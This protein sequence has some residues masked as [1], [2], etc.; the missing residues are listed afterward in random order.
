MFVRYASVYPL[1]QCLSITPV[2]IHYANVYPLRQ[3][4]SITPVIV[5]YA[6]V[7]PLH[8]FTYF[9]IIK[10]N[11]LISQIYFGMKL[12]MFR[13]VPVSI[14]R[15]YSLYTQQWYM[16]YRFVDSFRAG[17][18]S[19]A[20]CMTYTISECTVN[21]KFIAMHGRRNVKKKHLLYFSHMFRC[22]IHLHQGGILYP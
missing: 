10:Q 5:H 1:R 6:N 9:S 15:N 14:I 17:F 18:C 2:F 13:T 3:C 16:S 4:L 19:T 7:Y 22:Y 8:T 12:Y 21:K 20:V 11:A